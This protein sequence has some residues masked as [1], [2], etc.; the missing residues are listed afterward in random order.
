MSIEGR[1]IPPPFPNPEGP[2]IIP[3][4]VLRPQLDALTETFRGKLAQSISFRDALAHKYL[5]PNYGNLEEVEFQQGDYR[6]FV[7]LKEVPQMTEEEREDWAN[8]GVG[9]HAGW[10]TLRINRSP[11]EDTN[12][13]G[14]GYTDHL[15][16]HITEFE[17]DYD[18]TKVDYRNYREGVKELNT[19]AAFARAQEIVDNF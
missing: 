1:Y 7:Y 10:K 3:T 6:Y 15:E 4:E 9:P 2:N 13:S 5:Y 8:S 18:R 19:P 16:I 11:I 17:S 12:R 14:D